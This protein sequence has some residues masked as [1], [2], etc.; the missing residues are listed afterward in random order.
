MAELAHFLGSRGIVLSRSNGMDLGS[1]RQSNRL[2]LGERAVTSYKIAKSA[3]FE[4]TA[5]HL[6]SIGICW[7]NDDV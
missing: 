1:Q 4:G 3:M 2:V 7:R 5:Q 6:A